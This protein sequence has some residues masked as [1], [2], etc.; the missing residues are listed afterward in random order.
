MPDQ[1]ERDRDDGLEWG[2]MV[3]GMFRPL[4]KLPL[5][6]AGLGPPPFDVKMW[7]DTVRHVCHRPLDTAPVPAPERSDG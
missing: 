5:L 2:H 1:D 4:P 7:D 6:R 3:D